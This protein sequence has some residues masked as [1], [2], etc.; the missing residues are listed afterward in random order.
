MLRRLMMA[1]GGTP[2]V[3]GSTWD[4]AAKGAGVVLSSGDKVATK[5]TAGWQ[6][7]LGALGRSSGKY[8]FEI[9][10]V[11]GSELASPLIGIADKS[12]LATVLGTYLGNNGMT[13]KE[14]T[15]YWVP[16]SRIYRNLTSGIGETTGS[17]SFY[18]GTLTVA[19]D[20]DATP[21]TVRWYQ[22]GTLAG[23]VNL[24]TGATWFPGASVQNSATATLRTTGLVSPVAGYSEWG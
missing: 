14:S 18:S 8:Q 15:A 5:T 16:F 13:V 4:S 3:V 11:V 22:S 12:N 24:P 7:V 9:T 20:L 10:V 21:P 19:L 6:T 2:P 23:S 17:A 1:D